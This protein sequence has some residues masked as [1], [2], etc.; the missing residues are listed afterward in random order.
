MEIGKQ[1]VILFDL[2]GTLIDS[3][4]GVIRSVQY[5]QEKM[6]IPQWA[7]E[8][9]KF[10]VGPPLIKTFT[11]DFGLERETAEQ[12]I[13]VFRERYVPIGMFES[14]VYP[15]VE[16]M[17]RTLKANGKRLCVATS[18]KEA[19]AKQILEHFG[20]ARYFDMIGG[21]AR[22]IGRDT[23]AKVISYVLETMQAG[24]E[25]VVMVGD[26][27]FDVEGAHAVGIPCIAI[28]Y[29]YGDRTEFTACG[30]DYIAPTTESV[31]TLFIP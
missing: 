11:E 4:K 3:A 23:K 17:L 15:G 20:I 25:D 27:K 6:G 29:G 28:E 2:D 18:K 1:S 21:D 9:L 8:D 30:A 22:E 14:S 19:F 24:K 16:E 5:M 12:A 7:Y 13:A 26:R 10:V 31:V